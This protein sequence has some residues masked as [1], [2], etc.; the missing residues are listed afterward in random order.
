VSSAERREAD[1]E[2]DRGLGQLEAAK[3]SRLSDPSIRRRLELNPLTTTVNAGPQQQQQHLAHTPLSA[4][5]ATSLSAQFGYQ[6]AAYTPLSAVRQYN[7]QQWTPSPSVLSP[8]HG[9]TPQYFPP[10]R[11]H[12]PDGITPDSFYFCTPANSCELYQV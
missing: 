5:S 4:V 10:T 11:P 2:G 12:D 3:M 6:P 7:P 1:L 9:H 8:D